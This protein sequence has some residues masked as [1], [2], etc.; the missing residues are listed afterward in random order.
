MQTSFRGSIIAFRAHP[1]LLR[2]ISRSLQ[3]MLV[4]LSLLSAL[5]A[6]ADAPVSVTMTTENFGGLLIDAAQQDLSNPAHATF[7]LSNGSQLWFGLETQANPSSLKLQAADPLDDVVGAAFA[8]AGLL[9]PTD[10]VPKPADLIPVDSKVHL[11]EELNLAVAFT[12]PDQQMQVTLNPFQWSACALDVFGVVLEYLGMINPAFQI[13]L[14]KPRQV[15]EIIKAIEDAPKLAALVN[16]FI[17]GWHAIGTADSSAKKVQKM[18]AVGTDI[19]NIFVDAHSR[20]QLISILSKIV[21]GALSEASITKVVDTFSIIK[22]ALSAVKIAGFF[23]DYLLTFGAF[24]YHHEQY[25]TVILQSHAER[26]P[27]PTMQSTQPTGTI[28]EF[29]SP[30]GA[31]SLGGITLGPDG[32][33]WFTEASAIGRIT[34]AGQITEFPV[35]TPQSVPWGITKGPDGNLWFTESF[36]NNVGYITPT[37]Q[38]QEFSVGFG[39]NPAGITA[40]PDGNLWYIDNAFNR[41]GQMTL[42]GHVTEFPVTAGGLY[43]ITVGSDGNFWFTAGISALIERMTPAGQVTVFHLPSTFSGPLGITTGPDGNLWFTEFDGNKIGRITPTGQIT[44]FPI[45]TP[46]TEPYD[47]TMGPDGNLWFTQQGSNQIGSMTLSGQVTEFPIPTPNSVPSGITAG[48]GNTIWFTE[49]GGRVG[50]LALG[51]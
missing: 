30:S 31:S 23:V 10:V 25:P 3:A 39:T 35:P 48:P 13:G 21:Q 41:I 37:G 22:R 51:A 14:L 43:E 42:D 34:P 28:T 27:T 36:G 6:R 7:T 38:A 32:N 33:L 26:S 2:V 12:G 47:I 49:A 24:V 44:E 29:A 1:S 40:G 18:V 9:Q 4:I 19:L 16:D 11:F 17:S 15:A 50:R 5:P 46:G 8:S 20:E 45:P